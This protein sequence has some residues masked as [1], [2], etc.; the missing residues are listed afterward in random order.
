MRRVFLTS[1]GSSLIVWGYV[2][3]WFF[4]V[5]DLFDSSTELGPGFMVLGVAVLIV[6]PW[7]GI[8]TAKS[9]GEIGTHWTTALAVIGG[10]VSGFLVTLL[11]SLTVEARL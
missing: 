8:R 1:F 11:A 6:G 7:L 10:L 5:W 2:W 9:K 3:Y 4:F